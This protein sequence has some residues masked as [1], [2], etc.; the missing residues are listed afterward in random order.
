MLSVGFYF[1]RGKITLL[2]LPVKRSAVLCF[3][4]ADRL[5]WCL[6]VGWNETETTGSAYFMY[7]MLESLLDTIDI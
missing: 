1:F 6:A 3:S 7:I 5:Y 4:H 2:K